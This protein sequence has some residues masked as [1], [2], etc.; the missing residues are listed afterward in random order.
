MKQLVVL[1][2]VFLSLNALAQP[3]EKPLKREKAHQ[4]MQQ[5]TPEDHANLKTKRMTL[6][7]DLNEG[8]QKKVYQLLLEQ[9]INKQAFISER[10]NKKSSDNEF[11]K[12]DFLKMQNERLDQQIAFKSKMKSIL[13]DTQYEKFEKGI[14]KRTHQAKKRFKNKQ[15]RS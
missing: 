11:N 10:K 14:T 5:L 2:I 9:E 3:N 6:H 4:I 13:N 7:L 12:E 15:E 1:A 8:Q